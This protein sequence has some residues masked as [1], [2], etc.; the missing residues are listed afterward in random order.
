MKRRLKE[1][2]KLSYL[3]R[4][5]ILNM[6]VGHPHKLRTEIVQDLIEAYHLP[7]DL[8]RF[9]LLDEIDLTSPS[10]MKQRN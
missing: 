1:P 5:T 6:T 7:W 3:A 8:K 10:E 9:I 4:K 2:Q